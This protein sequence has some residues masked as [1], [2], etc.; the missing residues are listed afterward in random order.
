MKVVQNKSNKG[1]AKGFNKGQVPDKFGPDDIAPTG[2]EKNKIGGTSEPNM[3]KNKVYNEKLKTP[4]DPSLNAVPMPNTNKGN[5]KDYGM[6]NKIS[7]YPS[8]VGATPRPNNI[9]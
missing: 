7:D 5:T 2:G 3:D 4:R 9:S 6:F 8:K 1:N